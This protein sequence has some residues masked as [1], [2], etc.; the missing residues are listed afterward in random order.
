MDYRDNDRYF[1][2]SRF[3]PNQDS[4]Y[5][6]L[7]VKHLDSEHHTVVIDTEELVEALF[8]ATE[9][10]DLPG[11]ADVDASLLLFCN[12]VKEKCAVALSG[13]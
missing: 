6:G 8:M 12:R 9:A 10:R 3:Q 5:I 1:K 4:E 2:H 13:E 7:M 11:M